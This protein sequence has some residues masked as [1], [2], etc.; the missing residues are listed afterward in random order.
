MTNGQFA[1]T[2]WALSAAVGVGVSAITPNRLWW[3][4]AAAGC[5]VVTFAVGVIRRRATLPKPVRRT[6]VDDE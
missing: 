4:A 1:V 6:L 2:S 3:L 5:S